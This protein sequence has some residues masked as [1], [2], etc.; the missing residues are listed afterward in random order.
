M[1]T[2]T[3]GFKWKVLKRTLVLSRVDDAGGCETTKG[4]SN[5]DQSKVLKPDCTLTSVVRACHRQHL[6]G[7]PPL[8]TPTS[9]DLFSYVNRS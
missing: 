4:F 8:H 6:E 2:D 1:I 7:L 5:M 3:N 9:P